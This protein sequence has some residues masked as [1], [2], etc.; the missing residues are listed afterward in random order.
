[1]R[2]E[3][4]VFQRA[5]LSGVCFSGSELLTYPLATA[6]LWNGCRSGNIGLCREE[7]DWN[8][9]GNRIPLC[10]SLDIRWC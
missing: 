1:M 7:K 2:F 9:M 6:T 8:E 5:L 10:K 4:L 3:R